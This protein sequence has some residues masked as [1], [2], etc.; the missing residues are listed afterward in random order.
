[1][2]HDIAPGNKPKGLLDW[3]F[4]NQRHAVWHALLERSVK[5]FSVSG[6]QATGDKLVHLLKKGPVSKSSE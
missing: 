2:V 5:G 4:F 3:T 6:E 1:M